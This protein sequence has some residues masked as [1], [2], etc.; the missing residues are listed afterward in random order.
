MTTTTG[1][2]YAAHII[3]AT[4]QLGDPEVV[5]MTAADEVGAA[6]L[7]TAYPLA[8][9]A[10]WRDVLAG[11]GWRIVGDPTHEPY[12]IVPVSPVDWPALVRAV[13]FA[14]AQAQAELDRQDR[15]W[16]TVVRDAMVTDGVPRQDI[17][18]AAEVTVA[19]AYQIRDG[20][21]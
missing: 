20:R 6:D 8:D 16:R 12:T 13:T 11:H 14:R 5:I 18:E 21:R 19:R 2:A 15:A 9:D 4:D 7:I 1:T 17:A 3:T 10:D